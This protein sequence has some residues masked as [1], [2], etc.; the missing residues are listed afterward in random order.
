MIKIYGSNGSSAGRCLWLLEEIG[1][2]YERLDSNLR[3]PDGR[4]KYEAEVYAGGKVPFLIDDN[5]RLFESMA[6][7]GYLAAKYKPELI[8]GELYARA[9]LDQWS[10]WAIS[11]LQPE[12]MKILMHTTFLPEAARDP[13]QAEAGRAACAK[14]FAL[15]EGALT[16]DHLVGNRFT[17]ADVNCGSVVNLAVARAGIQPGPRTKA[18]IDRLRAR[19]ACQKIYG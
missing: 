11:T 12:V 5:V 10:Y 9:Q 2:P 16:G 1:V 15:L 19:P 3:E 14:C 4:A 6:I 7:N 13:K 18:W 17:L 8:P